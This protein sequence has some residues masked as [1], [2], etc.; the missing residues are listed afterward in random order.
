MQ[1]Q[2]PLNRLRYERERRGWS[3]AKLAEQVGVGNV[4]VSRWE[5]GI[6]YPYPPERRRLCKMYQRLHEELF[7]TRESLSRKNVSQTTSTTQTNNKPE[8]KLKYFRRQ[9]GLSQE[10]LAA[11]IG[12]SRLSL[13][14]CERGRAYPRSQALIILCDYFQKKPEELFSEKWI[15]LGKVMV[16][17]A[18]SNEPGPDED[19]EKESFPVDI[20]EVRTTM[21]QKQSWWKRFWQ[22]M[23][24]KH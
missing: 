5:N 23:Q 18:T 8:S 16:E 14:R 6:T 20:E 12:V 4:T 19:I 21:P 15:L 7:P 24:S 13:L 17:D 9:H 3:Q 22:K 11:R 2:K 10:E 1:T